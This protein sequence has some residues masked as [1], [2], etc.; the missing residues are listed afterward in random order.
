MEKIK[1]KPKS[2]N[3]LSRALIEAT[4]DNL[5]LEDENKHLK[6]I[7]KEAREKIKT[8]DTYY[9][10]DDADT[11]IKIGDLNELLEILDKGE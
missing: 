3:E 11:Y 6:S 7:I 10:E 1:L 4:T 8:L 5:F 9:N 2:Y